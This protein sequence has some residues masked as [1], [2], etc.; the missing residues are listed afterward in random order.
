MD[1]IEEVAGPKI[2]CT[3]PPERALSIGSAT[4]VDGPTSMTKRSALFWAI[5]VYCLALSTA[6]PAAIAQGP[7]RVE[8]NEVL[9]PTLVI[10]KARL[11]DLR[12]NPGSYFKPFLAGN[13][14]LADSVTEGLAIHDLTAVDF[15]LFEDGQLQAVQSV[16]FQRTAIRD[17]RDNE[18]FH[19]E[20]VGPGGGKW[21]TREWPPG[22]VSNSF[23]SYYVIAYAPPISVEGS[24]HKIKIEVN[25]R[26]ALVVARGE[27][28]NT[29]HPESDPLNGTLFGKQMESDL[30]SATDSKVG[31]TL[32]AVPL[33]N[34]G[35]TDRVHV[36]LDWRW[37]SLKSDSTTLG[38][39]GLVFAKD[40]SLNQR[41]SDLA[42]F[43]A[44]GV[45]GHNRVF[46]NELSSIAPTRYETQLF[47][48]PG[49]YRI[50]MVLSDGTK[51][52][53]AEIPLTVEIHDRESLSISAVALCKQIQ[54]VG[55][56][57]LESS[58]EVHGNRTARLP[59]SYHPLVS[60]DVEFEATGNTRFRKGEVLYA[61]FE[62][63]E[64]LLV[65]VLSLNVQLQL[66]IVDLKTGEVMTDSQPISAMP[67]VRPG[68]PVIPIGRGINISGL[69]T[70]SYGLDVR[71]TD[72]TGQSTSWRSVTFTEE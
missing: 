30:A 58:P 33:Y 63:F 52:G 72:S 22:V 42:E 21:S 65:R 53:R 55:T 45:E 16:S 32:A 18:G 3:I 29:K 17:V 4:H 48:P 57:S 67:Y 37:R 27:Y 49:E 56:H 23:P 31:V 54:N 68:N 44:G 60:N 13:I 40:G 66:R 2:V 7:I 10:D 61:Y 50:Q 6:P 43:N 28:C 71:V 12:S 26:N 64:P 19:T 51:F 38:V 9:V 36:I 15:R 35:N 5:V 70:G 47:L 1:Q 39:L 62:V 25:R 69:P 8:S 11:Q 14:Q 46:G 41:F 20:Y 34:D 59:A 24:C